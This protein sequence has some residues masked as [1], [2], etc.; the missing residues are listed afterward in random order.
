MVHVTNS[1]LDETSL[2]RNLPSATLTKPFIP[3]CLLNPDSPY[4]TTN[5][6]ALPSQAAS[7]VPSHVLCFHARTHTKPEAENQQRQKQL[8]DRHS[9]QTLRTVLCQ[10]QKKPTEHSPS[11]CALLQHNPDATQS[12]W[13]TQDAAVPDNA[14]MVGSQSDLMPHKQLT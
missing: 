10:T 12:C 1:A 6:R 3:A 8:A 13:L 14:T 4:P 2:S 11:L 7:A 9:R 5:P